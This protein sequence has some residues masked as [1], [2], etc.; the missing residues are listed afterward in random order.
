[1]RIE[2]GTG[3]EEEKRMGRESPSSMWQSDQ[4]PVCSAYGTN[5]KCETMGTVWKTDD[6]PTE[7]RKKLFWLAN[8]A[9]F[10]IY[11]QR[12]INAECKRQTVIPVHVASLYYSFRVT[13]SVFMRSSPY[14]L[15]LRWLH[16]IHGLIDRQTEWGWN[17][18]LFFFWLSINLLIIFL[19][20]P[21]CKNCPNFSG[22][23]YL[24]IYKISSHNSN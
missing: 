7:D 14:I 23:K 18:Q 10:N 9:S 5:L 6:Q 21:V 24:Q 3:G 15:H 4:E 2:K 16:Y 17:W 8:R 19:I 13:A 1:M 22:P 20:S 11:L 12:K